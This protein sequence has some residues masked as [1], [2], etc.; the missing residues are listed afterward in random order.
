VSGRTAV[1]AAS[2]ER[3]ASAFLVPIGRAL[4]AG[5]F[6]LAAGGHFAPDTIQRAADHGVPLANVLVPASGVL[7]LLGGLSVLVG[8]RTRLG[9]ALL[10]LFLIPVT[11]AMHAFWTA[12]DAQTA[13]VQM[14]MFMKNLS[15]VGGAMLL[16]HFGAG[17]HSLDA[18]RE[19]TVS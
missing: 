14:V 8:Y 11:F 5:I 3:T 18:R 10:V 16:I 9:A 4:F 19:E 1:G 12:P 15:L 7:S 17:P 2:L 6:I 13:Q